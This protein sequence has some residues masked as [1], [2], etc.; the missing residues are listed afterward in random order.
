MLL[1]RLGP[2]RARSIAATGSLDEAVG[3]LAGTAYG[4]A[5]SPGMDLPT[6]QRAIAETTLW[7]VRVL[8]GWAPPHA[9]EPVRALAAWFELANIDDRLAYLRGG[10]TLAPFALG[11]LAGVWPKIAGVQS[12][13]EL[14]AAL[15]GSVWGDPGT[16]D[17]AGIA[18]ALRL[19]WAARVLDAVD[20]AEEWVAGAVALLLAREL[21]LAGRPA[22]ELLA[23][24]WPG[25][26]ARWPTAS[27]VA[28][29]RAALPGRAAWVLTDVEAP[30]DLWRAEGAWWR[31]VASDAERL[32][33]SAILGREA[34]IGSIVLL[35]VDA[36]RTAAALEVAARGGRGT[37]MEV[38][39]DLA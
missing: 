8:A 14:R 29:L 37:A 11:G 4:R 26:G 32:A 39:E 27:D 12:A 10:P 5:V 25:A 6:A 36:W 22:G 19:S 33:R 24:R 20:E 15:V 2:E 30:A 17:P 34:L 18:L 21:L 9:I 23:R 35:G 3:A 38:F 1:R 7:H 31:R 13:G 28:S 16:D